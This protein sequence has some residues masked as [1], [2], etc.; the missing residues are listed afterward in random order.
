VTGYILIILMKGSIMQINNIIE[1]IKKSK[2][3]AV[4]P[5]VTVDGDSLGSSL[6]LAAALRKMDKLVQIYLEENAPQVYSFLPR[7]DEARIWDGKVEEYDLV[8]ALDTGDIERL[9]KRVALFNSAPVTVNIDHHKTNTLFAQ[10]NFVN[11][12]ASSV[13]EI[14]HE[15]LILMGVEI[16]RDIALYIYTAIAADTGG[17]RY[18]NTKQ[19]T[20]MVAAD[21]VSKGIDVAEVSRQ[22]FEIVS[23]EKLKLIGAA[24]NKIELFEEG[25]VALI[26]IDGEMIKAAGAKDEDTEGIVNYARNICGVEVGVVIKQKENGEIKIN[27]RSNRY[28]DVSLIAKKFNGGGHQRAAG[29]TVITDIETAKKNIIEEIRNAL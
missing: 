2:K 22:L 10:Y 20:H 16:D 5:H 19:S 29:C 8:I 11:A 21:L 6:A 9:G 25:T 13:G 24:V 26:I 15:F 17:F 12:S 1:V 23:I 3:V 14:I 18:S 4:L 27:L 28:V 7:I